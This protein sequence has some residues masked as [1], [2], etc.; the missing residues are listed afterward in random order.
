M[1]PF[2]EQASPNYRVLE[3]TKEYV[4]L[5][6]EGPWDKH[7][8][9]TNGVENILYDAHW[10]IDGRKL[11]YYDSEGVL[12]QIHYREEQDKLVFLGFSEPF[13]DKNAKLA[14][15]PKTSAEWF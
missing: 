15:L 3:S 13:D 10:N 14:E 7:L 12:T 2:R 11:L 1:Q 4:I 5:Q 9:I 6:D 8:T